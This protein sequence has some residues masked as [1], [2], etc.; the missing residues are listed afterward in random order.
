MFTYWFFKTIFLKSRSI[1]LVLQNHL[2]LEMK[3]QY[4]KV[5]LAIALYTFGSNVSDDSLVSGNSILRTVLFARMNNVFGF[6]ISFP[7]KK[8]TLVRALFITGMLP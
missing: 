4:Q 3:N 2:K 6:D 7:Y 1:Y 8:K 5:F